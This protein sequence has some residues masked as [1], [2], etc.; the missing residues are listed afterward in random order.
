VGCFFIAGGGLL[1]HILEKINLKMCSAMLGLNNLREIK[2]FGDEYGVTFPKEIM[3]W[4][5]IIEGDVL[6]VSV[7]NGNIVLQPFRVDAE[8]REFAKEAMKK[9]DKT[10]RAL[11]D[12]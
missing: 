7:V 1:A 6:K 9:Y 3:A 4:A 8:V 5:N 12:R 11:K 10:F 2:Q